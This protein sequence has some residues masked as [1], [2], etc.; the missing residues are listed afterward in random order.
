MICLDVILKCLI[1]TTSLKLSAPLMKSKWMAPPLP[2][3]RFN[4][5]LTMRIEIILLF[6]TQVKEGLSTSIAQMRETAIFTAGMAACTA[7]QSADDRA[8]KRALEYL[9]QV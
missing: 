5:L 6:Q 1:T 9:S 2:I 4:G 7:P 8:A 3:A